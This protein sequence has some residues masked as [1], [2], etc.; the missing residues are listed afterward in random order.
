MSHR[1]YW[2]KQ[3]AEKLLKKWGR[4][5]RFESEWVKTKRSGRGSVRNDEME[6]GEKSKYPGGW[7]QVNPL[8]TKSHLKI[9]LLGKEKE[10]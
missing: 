7:W 4:G 10:H 1:L 8:I 2:G 9:K 6:K 3:S 5:D